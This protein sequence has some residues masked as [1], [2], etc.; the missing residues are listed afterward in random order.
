[1]SVPVTILS[2]FLGSGKTTLLN[3]L[4]RGA[5][6]RRI[7]VIVNDFG[8]VTIDGL[9]TGGDRD[10]VELPGGCICCSMRDGMVAALQRVLATG[11]DYL[12]IETTGLADPFPVA[13][14]VRT[15]A[16]EGVARLDAV[17]TLVDAEN[18][19]AN[20]ALDLVAD[21]QVRCA[22]L[23]ILNKTDLAGEEQ[24]AALTRD[25]SR[26]NRRA[27]VIPA[28]H[29]NVSLELLL[30]VQLADLP[31]DGEGPGH[32]H[33]VRHAGITSVGFSRRVPLL[34]GPFEEFLRQ[35]PPG[36]VR[37]KGVIWLEGRS[38]RLIFHQVGARR[39][40]SLCDPWREGEAET[41]VLLIGQDL[42]RTGLLA[43]LNE[44]VAVALV[45]E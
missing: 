12:L 4:L 19:A 32:H 24:S 42:D 41:R 13:E 17:I 10:V 1:M 3:R 16:L 9:L 6:G 35:L 40:L 15:Q 33:D 34:A 28:A 36:I 37:A 18:H 43:A 30:D 21:D 2:G 31:G 20:R 27:R 14:T 45:P 8:E 44:C 26:L 29:A 38:E 7:G 25:L 5:G 23:L 22:D 39:S 11:V